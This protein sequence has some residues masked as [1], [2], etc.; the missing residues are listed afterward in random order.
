MPTNPTRAELFAVGRRAIVTTP[1]VKINPR[2]VDVPGSDINLN[3]GAMSAIGDEIVARAAAFWQGLFLDTAV[4][5]A[6]DRKAFDNFGLTRF[7]STPSKVPLQ[8]HR[9]AGG[10][11]GTYPAGSTVQTTDGT[12]FSTDVAVSFLV[13]DLIKA[14]NATALVSGSVGNVGK[15]LVIQFVSPPFDPT[16]AVINDAIASRIL[17]FPN[18]DGSAAGG[19]DVEDDIQ[20][21][22]RCR[23]FFPTVR[24]GTL[25][26]IEYGALQVPGVSV[27]TAIEATNPGTGLPVA[28]IQLVIADKDGKSV[29][30]LNQAVA[31][32]LLE[33]RA[34]GIPVE[35]LSGVVT[36]QQVQ[37]SL[38]FSYGY[39]EASIRNQI[40]AVTVAISQF[41]PPGPT[42][43]LLT[44]TLI[45]AAKTVRGVIVRNDALRLPLGDVVPVSN[46]QI[47]RIRPQ[48]VSF[49]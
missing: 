28:M 19:D 40:V 6:L 41:L 25:G 7:P 35:V 4:D 16:I 30:S 47:I 24:R 11:A 23:N 49:V 21:K 46:T 5:D 43:T 34:G 2:M 3:V 8:L 44:S 48:D 26:A 45:A 13:G 10:I 9:P 22:A 32:S 27:A 17:G 31:N 18:G 42:G 38:A 20:F 15:E 1:N 37:W 33:Y 12:Q 39:D 36:Y 29:P 14:V